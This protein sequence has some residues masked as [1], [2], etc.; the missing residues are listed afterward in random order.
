MPLPQLCRL[1]N[2]VNNALALNNSV[3]LLLGSSDSLRPSPSLDLALIQL[4]D[5]SCRTGFGLGNVDPHEDSDGHSEGT[6]Y[7]NGLQ[8]EREEHGRSGID[9]SDAQDRVRK[10]GD[11][12]SLHSEHCRGN[13][14]R[15][16]IVAHGNDR[17]EK[18]PE[19][20]DDQQDSATGSVAL[21]CSG[22]VQTAD[23]EEEDADER[24]AC[25]DDHTTANPVDRETPEHGRDEV[26]AGDDDRREEGV[27]LACQG[28]E[29][30]QVGVDNGKTTKLQGDGHKQDGEGAFPVDALE[31]VD[32]LQLAVL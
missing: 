4:V 16:E 14:G 26:A 22:P 32:K 28:E 27:L 18:R 15:E 24:L 19:A 13:F 17:E 25:A 8:I 7:K 12:P 21:G 2:S 1:P 5:L 10:E 3:H 9:G 31:D 20:A 6:E 30:G 23:D 29:V 11:G